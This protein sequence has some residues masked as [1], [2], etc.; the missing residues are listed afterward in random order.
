M[1]AP[2]VCVLRAGD[3]PEAPA[4]R[5]ARAMK[6]IRAVSDSFGFSPS[7]VTGPD[8]TFSV[9]WARQTAMWLVR[10]ETGLSN[11]EIGRLFGVRDSTTVLRSLERV[12]RKLAGDPD[13]RR[14]MNGMRASCA[15]RPAGPPAAAGDAEARTA[16]ARMAHEL[17]TMRNRLDEMSVRLSELSRAQSET[18]KEILND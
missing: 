4:L 18:V 15:A 16:I 3:R 5:S 14:W 9:S 10:R 17:I 12:E 2:A 6:I 7:V 11:P 8:R 1:S 13:L